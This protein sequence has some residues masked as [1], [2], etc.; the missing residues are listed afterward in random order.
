MSKKLHGDLKQQIIDFK[1]KAD[2]KHPA[3]T[4]LYRRK[5]V[6]FFRATIKDLEK[7]VD[8]GLN[9]HSYIEA[10][11]NTL[12][13]GRRYF[14]LAFLYALLTD[15]KYGNLALASSFKAIILENINTLFV[16]SLTYQSSELDAMFVDVLDNNREH[17]FRLMSSVFKDYKLFN[18]EL[19]DNMWL[20]FIDIAHADFE[21]F[22][23]H[24]D[25]H[26]LAFY[27]NNIPKLSFV[28]EQHIT[29]VATFLL[30]STTPVKLIRKVLSAMAS[31]PSIDILLIMSLMPRVHERGRS[32]TLLKKAIKDDSCDISLHEDD[33]HYFLLQAMDNAFYN[34]HQIPGQQKTLFADIILAMDFLSFLPRILEIVTD[35]ASHSKPKI[36]E[37][38]KIFASLLAHLFLAH[39]ELKQNVVSLL[40][41]KNIEPEI[42][43]I[44]NSVIRAYGYS[45]L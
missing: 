32:L 27:L 41:G 40:R 8:M 30:S 19:S 9:I 10:L 1:H 35:T 5:P 25:A 36:F 20:A 31:A 42:K 33:F 3:L 17:F 24:A 11:Y 28:P 18:A 38:R 22:V 37:T 6:P 23:V 43:R 13:D 4:A 21:S 39:N 7:D 14:D 16:K 29:V 12:V 26:F 2:T 34:F 44:I 15:E 45:D